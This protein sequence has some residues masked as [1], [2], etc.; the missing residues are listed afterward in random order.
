M[1]LLE[2]SSGEVEQFPYTLG[3]F[4]RDNAQTSFP[5]IIPNEMLAGY[6][7]YPVSVSSKPSFNLLTQTL[8]RNT[9]PTYQADCWAV[10]WI[11]TDLPDDVAAGNVRSLRDS[12]LKETDWMANSDVTM[13][14]EWRTYRQAL[15]DVP[16]QLPG[17]VTWPE[18]PS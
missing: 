12:K 18:E 11:V 4:R 5:R 17:A 3:D 16:S 13:S 1:L 15:R 8:T 7:V 14:N 6:G 2:T 10:G 9:L